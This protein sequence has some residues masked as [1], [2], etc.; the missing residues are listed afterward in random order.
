MK[1]LFTLT[2]N[3]YPSQFWVLFWGMLISRTGA[4]MIWPFLMIYVSEKLSLPMTS[5]G[6]LMAIT[7]VASLISSFA[8]GN[9]A[10]R[11]GRKIT[12]AVG[13]IVTGLIFLAM[14]PANTFLAFAIIMTIRGLF[15]PLYP[16]G[17]RAMIADLVPEEERADAYALAR[18]GANV[19]IALGP[20]IGGFVAAVSYS[21]AFYAAAVT[22]V[23]FGLVVWFYMK[24]TLPENGDKEETANGLQSYKVVFAD[25]KFM[26]FA[27]AATFAQ[28]GAVMMWVLLSVYAKENYGVPESQYGFIAATNAVMVVFLQ[29]YI[30]KITK[31]KRPL[32]I[33]A[34]GALFYAFGVASIA[35]ATSFISFWLSIIVI[36]MGELI[37]VPTATTYTANSA[38]LKMRGRYMSIF[39]LSWGLATGIGPIVGGLLND[40]ISPVSIWYGGGLISLVGAVM[41]F[42][43]FRRKVWE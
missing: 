8:I 31:E 13:L 12:M 39:T 43:Q 6:S 24:E 17:S 22:L 19:G 36:T 20:A 4:G 40:N 23:V 34:L 2:K 14:I 32:L 25:K 26:R 5:V 41:F 27:G 7:A 18:L 37:L 1:K 15:N 16:I 11:V 21:I 35:L 28:I 10:D 30:T 38:P 42:V 3:E 33:M 29:M 9:L